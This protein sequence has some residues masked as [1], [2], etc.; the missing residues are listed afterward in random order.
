MGAT[1]TL[2][3]STVT[4][5]SG[6]YVC[7]PATPEPGSELARNEELAEQLIMRLTRQLVREKFGE[8]SVRQGF[9]RCGI[10]EQDPRWIRY[11]HTYT[12]CW[13]Q[14]SWKN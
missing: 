9:V 1:S 6:E 13:V 8:E 11:I 12:N 10:I 4:G 14:S 2:Y 7:P 5:K 3:C